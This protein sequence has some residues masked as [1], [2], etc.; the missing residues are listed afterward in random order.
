[1]KFD[2]PTDSDRDSN[3]VVKQPIVLRND[4]IGY[5]KKTITLVFPSLC[6]SCHAV[7]TYYETGSQ[8]PHDALLDRETTVICGECGHTAVVRVS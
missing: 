6:V 5:S 2:I 4:G 8:Y 1:M 7:P 3:I